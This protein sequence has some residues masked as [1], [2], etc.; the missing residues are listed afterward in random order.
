VIRRYRYKTAI[1]SKNRRNHRCTVYNIPQLNN[2]FLSLILQ[3]DE[4]TNVNYYLRKE[5]KIQTCYREIY[6]D[7]WNSLPVLTTR[8]IVG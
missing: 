2:Y 3:V 7:N 6:I 8:L 5:E 4:A 1:D